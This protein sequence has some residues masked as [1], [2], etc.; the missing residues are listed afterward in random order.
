MRGRRKPSSTFTDHGAHQTAAGP[1]S[2]NQVHL[3]RQCEQCGVLALSSGANLVS[4]LYSLNHPNDVSSVVHIVQP[5]LRFLQRTPNPNH[6]FRLSLLS[7]ISIVR[8]SN[9][10][11]HPL[12]DSPRRPFEAQHRA[13]IPLPYYTAHESSWPCGSL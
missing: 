11:I 7:P 2:E 4:S 6:G 10:E 9:V 13:R 1:D 5:V 8:P 3:T 12:S